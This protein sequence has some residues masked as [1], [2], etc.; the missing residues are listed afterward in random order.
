MDGLTLL[1]QATASSLHVE[2]AGDE[3]LLKGPRSCSALVE[4]IGRRKAEVIA[5]LRARATTDDPAAWTTLA[6]RRWGG[7]DSTP[8][9]DV[10]PDWRSD[11]ASWPPERWL[12][13]R[14]RCNALIPPKAKPAEVRA[15]ERQA[16]DETNLTPSTNPPSDNLQ[17]AS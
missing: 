2:I 1:E 17:E 12:A 8:G 4:E 15:A 13:W 9:L 6:A 14:K 11:L 10:P 3:L 16:Y 7:A 5:E